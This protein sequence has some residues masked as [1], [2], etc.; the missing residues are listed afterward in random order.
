MGCHSFPEVKTTKAI[1]PIMNAHMRISGR[2]FI[3]MPVSLN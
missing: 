2:F 1:I 3:A